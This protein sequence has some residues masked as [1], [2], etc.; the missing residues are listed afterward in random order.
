MPPTGPVPSA[1]LIVCEQRSEVHYE[2]KFRYAGGQ[3]KRRIGP[4]WLSRD[5]SGGWVP[6]RGRVAAGYF[7]ERRAHVAAA[8]I[9]Q[10]FVKDSTRPSALSA[11]AARAG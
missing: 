3:V 9:V 10:S 2:A 11:S 4:A 7:D 1:A 6:R 8:E 5:G